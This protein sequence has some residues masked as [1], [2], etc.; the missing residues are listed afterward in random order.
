MRRQKT[1][2]LVPYIIALH[3]CK[4]SSAVCRGLLEEA[5]SVPI[6]SNERFRPPIS[7]TSDLTPSPVCFHRIKTGLRLTLRQAGVNKVYST[8][9]T[10]IYHSQ[11]IKL[12]FD[13]QPE[14][15]VR[16]PPTKLSSDPPFISLVRTLLQKETS[17]QLSHENQSIAG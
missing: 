5:S 14:P 1:G 11:A 9:A 7:S 17:R 4:L 10:R 3:L 12:P 16:G 13:I 6:V 15:P 2:V 8:M